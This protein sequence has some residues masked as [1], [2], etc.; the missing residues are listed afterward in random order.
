LGCILFEFL[1]G[2]PPFS[3]SN[4]EDVWA[5]VVNWKTVLER[6]VYDEEDIDFNLSDVAWDLISKLFPFYLFLFYF[7]LKH[8]IQITN[9][10]KKIIKRLITDQENRLGKNGI[11]EIKAHEFFE[12]LDWATLRHEVFFFFFQS[13]HIIIAS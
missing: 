3:G 10:N 13:L 12:G 2:Y 1:S 4:V 9:K 7:Y 6:P 5:N 8:K 11:A